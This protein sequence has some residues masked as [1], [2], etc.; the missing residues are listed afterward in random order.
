M[1]LFRRRR[2]DPA[3]APLRA[4]MPI[5]PAEL[6]DNLKRDY[7]LGLDRT[8]AQMSGDVAAALTRHGPDGVAA[9]VRIVAEYGESRHAGVLGLV[10]EHNRVRGT[11]LRLAGSDYHA[12]YR[13]AGSMLPQ[14]PGGHGLKPELHARIHLAPALD[15]VTAHATDLDPADR[16]ATLDHLL[17]LVNL[18]AAWM[19]YTLAGTD[20]IDV[21]ELRRLLTAAAALRAAAGAPPLPESVGRLLDLDAVVELRT[22]AVFVTDSIDQTGAGIGHSESGP[23]GR[24][25]LAA[26]LR[27]HLG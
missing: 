17:R 18:H 10:A 5:Q 25:D 3:D 7:R 16:T 23:A 13:A 27:E 14:Q 1:R 9:A 21:L 8:Y 22:P 6:T 12:V 26:L 20:T 24:L 11:D 4:G 2:P 15:V 19:M